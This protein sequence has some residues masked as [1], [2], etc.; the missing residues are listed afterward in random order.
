MERLEISMLNRAQP[1]GVGWG[2]VGVCVEQSGAGAEPIS[3]PCEI[4]PAGAIR[5]ARS[6]EG[7]R[8]LLAPIRSVDNT[9]M[10]LR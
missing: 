3:A 7:R 10:S 2:Y 1:E 5:N 6:L 8:R 9:L 4:K